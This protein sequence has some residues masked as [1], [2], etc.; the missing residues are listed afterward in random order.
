VSL[1]DLFDTVGLP[2]THVDNKWGW[3]NLASVEVRQVREGWQISF[4]PL[5]EIS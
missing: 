3:T 1:A 2:A 4:P 5:E